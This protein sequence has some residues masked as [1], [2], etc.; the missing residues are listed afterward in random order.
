MTRTT[1]ARKAR[2][3]AAS[4]LLRLRLPRLPAQVLSDA[5]HTKLPSRSE[6]RWGSVARC[7]CKSIENTYSHGGVEHE[8]R[9]PDSP[10]DLN[11][12]GQW[13]RELALAPLR[14]RE[15]LCADGGQQQPDV[16]AHP[17]CSPIRRSPS[18]SALSAKTGGA[19]ERTLGHPRTDTVP[20]PQ[21][22][23]RERLPRAVQ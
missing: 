21:E 12:F 20:S 2:G 10:R 3:R 18:M 8:Q 14:Y 22:E 6:S 11:A 5:G 15:Q 23:R 7:R 9:R 19:A 13:L 17:H 4:T 16:L 1:T